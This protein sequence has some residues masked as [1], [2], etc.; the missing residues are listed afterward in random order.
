MRA[1]NNTIWSTIGEHEKPACSRLNCNYMRGYN[2]A[3][4]TSNRNLDFFSCFW[5]L[6]IDLRVQ[7]HQRNFK[8]ISFRNSPQNMSLRIKQFPNPERF[9]VIHKPQGGS[10]RRKVFCMPRVLHFQR[11]TTP[12][13]RLREKD[14]KS[15]NLC[16]TMSDLLASSKCA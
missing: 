14:N 6:L 4:Y 11:K 5:R 7:I 10:A 15:I 9:R 13:P 1:F 16:A 12:Q 2:S 3:D 8:S